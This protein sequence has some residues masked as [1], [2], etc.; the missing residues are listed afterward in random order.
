MNIALVI[1]GSVI[2]LFVLYF[3]YMLLKIKFKTVQDN[4]KIKNKGRSL[5]LSGM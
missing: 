4:D 1:V 5:R 3:L 2:T